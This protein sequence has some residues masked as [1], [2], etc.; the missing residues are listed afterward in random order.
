MKTFL[1]GTFHGVTH[2][3]LQEYL[4]KFLYMRFID[5]SFNVFRVFVFFNDI[6]LNTV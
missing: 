5:T 4:D 6:E 3:Y 2:K 1:N